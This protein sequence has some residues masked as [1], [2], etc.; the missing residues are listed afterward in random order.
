MNGTVKKVLVGSGILIGLYLVLINY[1][2]FSSDVNSVST[3]SVGVVKS[4]Q[5]R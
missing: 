2:G 3:G 1:T 4:L 5:G